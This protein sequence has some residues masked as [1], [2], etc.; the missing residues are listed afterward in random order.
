M[1]R[2]GEILSR[3]KQL[4]QQ[5]S[6]SEQQVGGLEREVGRLR[7]ALAE[8][9][10]QRRREAQAHNEEGE[11]E[12]GGNRGVGVE[13]GHL[14][15]TLPTQAWGESGK[16]KQKGGSAK[17]EQTTSDG[18]VP[19]PSIDDLLSMPPTTTTTT[20][21]S[22]PTPDPC[23]L[24]PAPPAVEG[25]PP[26]PL[27]LQSVVDTITDVDEDSPHHPPSS[28]PLTQGSAH[29]G[30]SV[31][32]STSKMAAGGGSLHSKVASGSLHSK[33]TSGSVHSKVG[34]GSVQSKKAGGVKPSME[35]GGGGGGKKD[36]FS[37]VDNLLNS[38][39]GGSNLKKSTATVPTGATLTYSP[40]ATRS[41]VKGPASV[42]SVSSTKDR[43]KA[44]NS[45]PRSA[46]TQP[47]RDN[48]PKTDV[49][50]VK[51][52]STTR[53]SS[54]SSSHG[55]RRRGRGEGGLT[56]HERIPTNAA[57]KKDT[58]STKLTSCQDGGTVRSKLDPASFPLGGNPKRRSKEASAK[59]ISKSDSDG[60]KVDGGPEDLSKNGNIGPGVEYQ[61][62]PRSLS[63]VF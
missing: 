10:Q 22:N 2:E 15:P 46:L 4:C 11:E 51:A 1:R 35:S 59:V 31:R 60:E 48:S 44:R 56:T 61:E 49:G 54:P 36:H 52:T 8:Q 45:P 38:E 28:S 7:K 25:Q 30:N 12:K 37:F 62:A 17:L 13:P 29:Q 39:S 41:Q 55:E 43:P 19:T 23:A 24:T 14:Y 6:E 47:K 40:R 21:S 20:T 5:V 16:E 53:G 27:V 26:C 63:P 57:P 33:V 18:S 9:E 3:W 32:S 58:Q 50:K 34:S 42:P